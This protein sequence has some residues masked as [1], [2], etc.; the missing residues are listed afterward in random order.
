MVVVELRWRRRRDHKIAKGVK[1][2]EMYMYST[3]ISSTVC[4]FTNG[5]GTLKG[6]LAVNLLRFPTG[7]NVSELICTTAA[8][9]AAVTTYSIRPA[10]HH[11]RRGCSEGPHRISS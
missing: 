7:P 11:L 9:A 8:A 4:A 10:L 6:A 3:H 5:V 1:P 2:N